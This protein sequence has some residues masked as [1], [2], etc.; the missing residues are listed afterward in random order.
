MSEIGLVYTSLNTIDN[1]KVFIPNS[2]MAQA[3]IVNFSAE[4]T[5]RLDLNFTVTYADD[6]EKAKDVIGKVA[7]ASG[8]ALETPAPV[9]RVAD[10]SA[11]G[12]SIT[13]RIWVASDNYFDLLFYMREQVK[14]GI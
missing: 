9:I 12:M 13:S 8:L 3:R 2:D 11:T 5:R 14:A 4:P 7:K 6:F 1:K 10:H